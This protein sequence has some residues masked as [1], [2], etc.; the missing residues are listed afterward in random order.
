MIVYESTDFQIEGSSAVTLGNFDGIHLGHQ[1]LIDTVKK[2]SESENLKSV[3]FSFYP[4]PVSFF[5]STHSFQTLLSPQEKMYVAEKMGIDVLV[6]YPFT[7]DFASLTPE[8]FF[9]LLIQ[10]TNCK[11]LVVGENYCFGKGRAGDLKKL[12]SLGEKYGVRVIGIPSV[13]YDGERVSSTRIR[14][15]IAKGDM[16]EVVRLLSKPY[17]VI[18]RVQHGDKRGRQMNFPTVN[19]NPP[20]EKMLPPDGVYFSQLIYEGRRYNG[21]TNVGTNPTFGKNYRR[22]ETHILNFDEEIY[23]KEVVVGLFKKIREEVRF[24]NMDKLKAQL[25]K[26]KAT[27]LAFSATLEMSDYDF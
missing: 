11:V 6:Q 26:D 9:E 8:A 7:A 24:E 12:T 25:E 5:D 10:K 22:V 20:I 3:M 16:E 4:H 19:Q 27:A 23:G 13:H 15:L 21:I 17:L 14:G 2:Y 1:A 18:G